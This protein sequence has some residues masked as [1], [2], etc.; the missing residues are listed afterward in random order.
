[1]F[2]IHGTNVDTFMRIFC[3]V[4]K[5]HIIPLKTASVVFR[6]RFSLHLQQNYLLLWRNRN[7]HPH[8][9]TARHKVR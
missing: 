9:S 5:V 7:V 3:S 6:R 2:E 4:L 8:I 1:M